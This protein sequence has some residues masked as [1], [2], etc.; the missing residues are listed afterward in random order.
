M[1]NYT[2]LFSSIVNS[3]IWREANHVRLVW[4]TMLALKDRDGIVESSVPGLADAARVSLEECEQA[5]ERL[6]SP[7]KYSR[8]KDFEGRRIAECRGGW[9]VLNHDLYRRLESE[10]QRRE[11]NAERVRRYRERSGSETANPDHEKSDNVTEKRYTEPEKR[12]KSSDVT[13]CNAVKRDVTN[14]TPSDQIRSDPNQIRS[15]PNQIRSDPNQIRSDPNQI[16]SDPNYNQD[17]GSDARARDVD[18]P[19]PAD[20]CLTPEQ[21]SVLETA[22]I[23]AWAIDALT[24]DFVASQV[25]G[26]KPR[27]RSAWLKCL[28]KS[29]NSAWNNPN[30]RPKKPEIESATAT[31]VPEKLEFTEAHRGLAARGSIDINLFWREFKCFCKS[32]GVTSVNWSAAF[33][34]ELA[35]SIE[36]IERAA[37]YRATERNAQRDAATAP[38]TRPKGSGSTDA[39][40]LPPKALPVADA[41]KSERL[42]NAIARIG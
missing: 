5:I 30:R 33:E 15:D 16:R 6:S 38:P 27:P 40:P 29:I 1:S 37:Q 13:Q 32:R 10:E 9:R 8:T 22:M 7:D 19:C 17:S 25:T 36:R 42:R 2:K 21:R 34:G 26:S 14:V 3:T 41:A 23:P 35:K 4:I 20:L 12:Y 24:V 28:S 11:A 18:I 31:P 39:A